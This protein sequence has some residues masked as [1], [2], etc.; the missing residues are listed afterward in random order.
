MEVSNYSKFLLSKHQIFVQSGEALLDIGSIKPGYRGTGVIEGGTDPL[1]C[2]G[3][4][5]WKIGDTDQIL[6]VLWDI[7]ANGED[8]EDIQNTISIG[9]M[10]EQDI[11]E[12]FSVM[13]HDD[14]TSFLRKAFTQDD[15]EKVKF[16]GEEYF[17]TARIG[18]GNSFQIEPSLM[19][20]KSRL[21]MFPF[22]REQSCVVRHILPNFC[23]K[24]C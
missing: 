3:V 4:V 11:S 10:A 9:L 19:S 20:N 14:A 18:T 22:L 16:E 7:P 15:R 6:V 13:L 1:S 24:H 5:S 2:S 17:A 21:I 12:L 23:Q 8:V